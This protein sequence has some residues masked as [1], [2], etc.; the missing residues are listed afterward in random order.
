MLDRNING[1]IS[2]STQIIF[3]GFLGDYSN[4]DWFFFALTTTTKEK[5]ITWKNWK[6]YWIFSTNRLLCQGMER[7]TKETMLHLPLISRRYYW[8]ENISKTRAQKSLE[9]M[10]CRSWRGS[11]KTFFSDWFK[12]SIQ[13]G[14]GNCLWYTW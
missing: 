13:I 2:F 4:A 5:R 10:R 14:T 11:W 8:G 6:S 3:I 1:D 12:G 9:L 7:W